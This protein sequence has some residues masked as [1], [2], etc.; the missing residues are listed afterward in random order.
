MIS[1]EALYCIIIFLCSDAVR[2]VFTRLAFLHEAQFWILSLQIAISGF[3]FLSLILLPRYFK[4]ILTLIRGNPRLF[5]LIIAINVWHYGIGSTVSVLSLNYTSAAKAAFLFQFVIVFN[6]VNETIFLKE[7]FRIQ[8]LIAICMSFIG[9]W[10]LLTDG[11]NFNISKGDILPL[12]AALV[13]SV[14][15]TV[16]RSVLRKNTIE[17]QI[18]AYFRPFGLFLILPFLILLQEAGTLPQLNIQL[19]AWVYSKSWWYAIPTGGFW[20][21]TWIYLNRSYRLTQVTHIG[22]VSTL[23]PILVAVMSHYLLNEY[24]TIRQSFGASLI[25]I[26]MVWYLLCNKKPVNFEFGE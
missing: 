15:D 21:I 8:L 18:F 4:K 9:L 11:Q 6:A 23:K 5:F 26:S 20:S 16:S 13:W 1:S 14:S 2:I 12:T 24:M 17:P 22:L 3:I 10:L 25:V 7:R 19:T